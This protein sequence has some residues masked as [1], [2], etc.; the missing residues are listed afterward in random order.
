MTFFV[1]TLKPFLKFALKRVFVFRWPGS[2]I[3]SAVVEAVCGSL[4]VQAELAENIDMTA[5]Q[6]ERML[7]QEFG[8]CLT[9]ITEAMFND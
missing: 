8:R 5:A 1:L 3:T 4:L 6:A 9:Q 2:V 7:L